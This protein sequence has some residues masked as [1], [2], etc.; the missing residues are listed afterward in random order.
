[1]TTYGSTFSGIGGLDIAV[2]RVF[3]ARPLWHVE[4]DRYAAAVLERRWPGV[5][6]LKRVEL[7]DG[8]T[9]RPDIICGGFPCTDISTA[10]RGAGLAGE[11]SGLWWEFARAIGVLRPRIV[12]LE[13]VAALLARGLADV[14]GELARLGFDAEWSTLRASD[15]GAP[16]RRNRVFIVAISNAHGIG[17]ARH[18]ARER[19][20]GEGNG[21]TNAVGCRA[22]LGD[23]DSSR[24]P[25]SVSATSGPAGRSSPANASG[26]GDTD[27]RGLGV[28]GQPGLRHIESLRGHD[29]HGLDGHAPWPPSPG[30]TRGWAEWPGALPGVRRGA[31]GPPRGLDARR[32][33]ARLRCLGNAVVPQQAEAAIRG[34]WERL[35]ERLT[36]RPTRLVIER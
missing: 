25:R 30:D 20:P 5:P 8:N 12:V 2:E 26:V 10:G 19:E 4:P 6:N 28:H 33:R 7:I 11:Q 14:L 17:L 16:H 21:R 32:R 15:V 31:Y 1:M 29:P 13:N 22:G 35:W 36:A 9:P 24:W 3:G 18:D 27:G 34:L 23:S